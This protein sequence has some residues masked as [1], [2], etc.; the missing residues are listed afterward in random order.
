[1]DHLGAGVGL[2]VVV[3]DGH[4]VE[5]AH[6]VVALQHA[7]RVLPRDGGTRLHLCPRDFGAG[8]FAQATFGHE[9]VDA[10]L[11][12]LVAGEPV[13]DCGILHFGVVE[14]DDLH[15]SCVELVFVALG[16]GAA[17]KVAH[18]RAFVGDEEG[19]LEL[20]G[21]LGVDAEIGAQVDGTAHPLGDVAEGALAEHRRVEG[22]EKV[23]G[24]GHHRAEVLLHKVGVFFHRL[25][26]GAEEDALLFQHVGI[27]CLYRHGVDDGV[28]G[29]HRVGTF[30]GL[31]VGEGFLVLIQGDAEFVERF[32]H[33][34]K[35]L[36]L[37]DGEVDDVLVVRFFVMKVRPVGFL[38]CLP[39]AERFKAELQKP[40]GFLFS[41]RNHADNLLVQTA[42]KLLV[43][44]LRLE[45]VL[46]FLCA[47]VFYDVFFHSE[48]K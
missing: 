15:D 12:I 7:A 48:K 39:E 46:V 25:T 36:F 24:G 37:G 6:G 29:H 14:G 41:R 22:G 40:F 44:N 19:A 8:T 28:H 3:G 43:L 11:A 16:G 42:R 38:H 5:L 30:A 13:L 23:V 17:L 1:M 47:Y 2:L 35:L 18:V 9:V 21:V 34:R 27:H 26:E 31:L 4:G 20:A 33:F 10:A 32:D 45:S